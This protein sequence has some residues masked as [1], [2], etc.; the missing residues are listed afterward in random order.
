[1]GLIDAS[2]E[3]NF[4]VDEASRY[5]KIAL[6]CTQDTPNNRPCMS[7]VV[8]MLTGDTDVDEMIISKP[9]LLSQLSRTNKCTANESST[10]R[11]EQIDVFLSSNEA[12]SH[13]TMTF[14]SIGD[15]SN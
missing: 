6:L 1:M 13:G 11:G 2:L 7:T 10:K 5:I 15:R 3:G 9:V 8:N 4:S 12:M 14:T